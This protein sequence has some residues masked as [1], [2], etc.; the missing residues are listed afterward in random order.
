MY[1]FR[2]VVLSLTGP[3]IMR[4][5]RITNETNMELITDTSAA[6]RSEIIAVHSAFLWFVRVSFKVSSIDTETFSSNFTSIMGKL[7]NYG[8]LAS[9]GLRK[10]NLGVG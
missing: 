2:V 4:C 1:W 6:A 10:A 3:D 5:N 7:V 8:N 9:T